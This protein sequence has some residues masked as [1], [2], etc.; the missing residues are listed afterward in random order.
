MSKSSK[1]L[2]IFTKFYWPEGGGAEL[3]IHLILSMFS[4]DF[5][6]VIV[7]GT[8]PS[9]VRLPNRT[10]KYIHWTE[11]RY[12]YKPTELFC[13]AMLNSAIRRS[14]ETA[15]VVFVYSPLPLAILAKRTCPNAKLIIHLHNYQPV[16]YTSVVF[17]GESASTSDIARTVRLELFENRKVHKALLSSIMTFTNRINTIALHYADNI[18]C[19]SKRQ[20]EILAGRVKGVEGKIR[21]IYNPLPHYRKSVK[22]PSEKPTM[23]FLGGDSYI[24]GFYT[25]LNALSDLASKSGHN[26]L[27]I[28]CAGKFASSSSIFP[29]GRAIGRVS[30]ETLR[31][32]YA[33]SWGLLAPSIVEETFSYAVVEA[34]ACETIPV[35]SRV[36]AIP[37]I[38]KG[39]FGEKMLFNPSDEGEFVEKIEEVQSLSKQDLIEIG[40]KLKNAVT[41]KFDNETIKAHLRKVLTESAV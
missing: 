18:I 25:L 7:S 28:T 39:T 19:V 33:K 16:S 8:H 3:A 27:E 23:L 22:V 40:A 37:E 20:A 9:K 11:L 41:K 26:S 31:E 30:N 10:S 21:I 5:E 38:V 13:V 4:Q 12:N 29:F 36:G 35:A 14:L 32:L 15:D 1:T 2:V 24:K 6:M 34:M 17:C